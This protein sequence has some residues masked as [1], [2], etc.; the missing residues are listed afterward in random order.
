[1]GRFDRGVRY[2]TKAELTMTI[3]FPE[4]DIRCQWCPMLSWNDSLK[5]GRCRATD[6]VIYSPFWLSPDCPL[7]FKESDNEI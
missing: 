2:Y 3:G 7:I 4:D 5:I 1:M 6:K